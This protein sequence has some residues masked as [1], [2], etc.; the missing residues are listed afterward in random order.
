[1]ITRRCSQRQFL[2]RPDKKTNGVFAYCLAEAAKRHRI[3][4]IAWIAMSNHFH[5]VVHDPDQGAALRSEHELDAHRRLL[6]V[7]VFEVDQRA[8]TVAVGERPERT[9]R[10]HGSPDVRV[11][12]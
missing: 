2:L 9:L 8:R 11:G 1:L 12:A 7:E 3:Q 5:A 6:G 4:L 10:I